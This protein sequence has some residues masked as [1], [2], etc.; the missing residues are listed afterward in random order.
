MKYPAQAPVR[1]SSGKRKESPGEDEGTDEERREIAYLER[2]LGIKDGKGV[3][4]AD[5]GFDGDLSLYSFLC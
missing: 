3:K 1:K 2:K 4:S 5:D